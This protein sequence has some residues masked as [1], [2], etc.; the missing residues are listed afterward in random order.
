MPIKNNIIQTVAENNI[1]LKGLMLSGSGTMFTFGAFNFSYESVFL[2]V[3]GFM[4]AVM[5]F[6]YDYTHTTVQKNK[7]ELFS[8]AL[9]HLLFGTFAFPAVYAYLQSSFSFPLEMVVFLSVVV[10]YSVMV[11]IPFAIEVI[12]TF[13]RG[14]L[15]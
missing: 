4:V 11:F 1:S 12:K 7:H 8:E 13:L 9:R 14:F 10:S 5:S 15:K 2:G 3:A 6:Y